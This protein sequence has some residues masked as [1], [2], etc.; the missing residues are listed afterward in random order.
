ML[1]TEA[2][3]HELFTISSVDQTVRET[4]PGRGMS[5]VLLL[6]VDPLDL[7][8]LCPTCRS[9]APTRSRR[10]PTSDR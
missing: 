6:L 7:V 1:L 10:L 4:V 8:V 5:R 9:H 3:T 2:E